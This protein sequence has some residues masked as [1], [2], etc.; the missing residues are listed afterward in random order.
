[1]PPPAGGFIGPEV[2][3]GTEEV[4]VD[5]DFVRRCLS[6]YLCE[7]GSALSQQVRRAGTSCVMYVGWARLSTPPQER[8]VVRKGIA[9]GAWV[10]EG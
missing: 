6:A 1:M 3:D 10:G 4:E 8:R 2:A 7:P 5:A 9:K